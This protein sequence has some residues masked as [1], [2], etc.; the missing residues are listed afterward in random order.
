MPRNENRPTDAPNPEEGGSILINFV[1]DKSG[2]MDAVRTATIDGFNEFLATQR[3][4][5]G[6]AALT[7]HLFDT[8]FHEVCRAVPLREV[9][10]LDASAYR[11]SGCTALYDA[12]ARSIQIADDH[13]SRLDEAPDQILFVIMT[14]GLEN[15]SREF[16][17][18]Q[19]FDMIT[20][21]ERRG[22]EFVYLGANQDAYAE[23]G[24]VGVATDKA[25]NW[26]HSNQGARRA[27]ERLNSQVTLYRTM[28]VAH[29][30]DAD[31]SWFEPDEHL[32]DD[33]TQAHGQAAS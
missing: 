27:H 10:E 5:P 24:R 3:T 15:A 4:V 13:L 33:D 31:R 20:E 7:F 28:N 30:A 21:R 25:R 22:Y 8:E 23:A 2:S 19:V 12:V 14:D 9:P 18:R 26:V 1:L 11:P 16:S 32:S 29:L 17:Q 6:E